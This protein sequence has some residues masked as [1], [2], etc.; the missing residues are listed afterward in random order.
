MTTPF[1]SALVAPEI[2]TDHHQDEARAE[3]DELRLEIQ[4]LLPPWRIEALSASTRGR[5]P[6]LLIELEGLLGRKPGT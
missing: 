5:L 4:A 1:A 3:L 6:E 2:A